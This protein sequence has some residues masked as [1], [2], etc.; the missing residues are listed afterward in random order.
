MAFEYL[1]DKHKVISEL[2]GAAHTI[3]VCIGVL[4]DEELRSFAHDLIASINLEFQKRQNPSAQLE[5]SPDSEAEVSGTELRGP[6]EAIEDLL[7]RHPYGLHVHE[8]VS[9][10]A[11]SIRTTSK[12]P[13]DVLYAALAWLRQR[14]RV[15]KLPSKK[16]VLASRRNDES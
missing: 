3:G 6:V 13:R 1:R 11:T 7:A 15:A 8:I 2:L 16:Y 14:G 5:S 4:T 12:S 9:H 10:L